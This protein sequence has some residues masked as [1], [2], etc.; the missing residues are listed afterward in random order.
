MMTLP[1]CIAQLQKIFGSQKG[2]VQVK[3]GEFP[4][5]MHDC[6]TCGTMVRKGNDDNNF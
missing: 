5:F 2:W 1:H 6:I 3:I 4:I